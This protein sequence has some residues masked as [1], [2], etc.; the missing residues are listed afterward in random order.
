MSI[1]STIHTQAQV[2][3][4]QQR[5]RE[6]GLVLMQCDRHGA[7]APRRDAR[8]DWLSDLVQRS[9]L[10]H[11][12][13]QRA[14]RQWS[15]EDQPQPAEAVPGLWLAPVPLHERRTRTGYI[16][17]AIPTRELLT[18]E[19]FSA[20]CQS[21]RLDITMARRMLEG[22]GLPGSSEVPR[23]AALF[24]F[25]WHDQMVI[26]S[27]SSTLEGVGREL[28]ESYEEINLLYTIIQGMTVV[29]RPDRFI[30]FAC[31]ELL[32]TLPYRW[33]AASVHPRRSGGSAELIVAGETGRSRAA[34]ENVTGQLSEI[35]WRFGCGQPSLN[36]T[37]VVTAG[38]RA[39]WNVN[40]YPA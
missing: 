29:E 16:I 33:I 38:R 23:L 6:V 31:E 7:P 13:L 19:Q 18:S 20:M 17:A 37:P 40:R 35:L 28:G 5:L 25:N 11:R 24:R 2:T 8:R 9:T 4:L 39:V 26:D 22:L 15:I 3:T 14:A 27:H 30:A 1:L 32:H 36:P 21:A 12:G 34:I 10:V